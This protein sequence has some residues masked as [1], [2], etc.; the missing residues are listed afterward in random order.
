MSDNTSSCYPDRLEAFAKSTN[1]V[2]EGLASRAGKLGEA[3]DRYTARCGGPSWVDCT[4]AAQAVRIW[5]EQVRG[6]GEFAGAV[7]TAFAAADG[8]SLTHELSHLARLSTTTLDD[9]LP[10]QLASDGDDLSANSPFVPIEGLDLDH[11]LGDG[12]Q[13]GARVTTS[14]DDGSL[15]LTLVSSGYD[16]MNATEAAGSLGKFLAVGTDGAEAVAAFLGTAS[17]ALSIA[18][19]FADEWFSEPHTSTGFRTFDSAVVGGGAVG[20]AF[21]GGELS[22][23]GCSLLLGPE[24][25]P[26]CGAV[27]SGVASVVYAFGGEHLV[28]N[29]VRWFDHAVL[30][31]PIPAPNEHDVEA[32][33]DQVRQPHLDP[34]LYDSIAATAGRLA[35][36]DI[37][38]EV[39]LDQELQ[40]STIAEVRLLARGDQSEILGDTVEILNGDNP[41]TRHD[42]ELRPP[43]DIDRG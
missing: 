24:A 6:L 37:A 20:A 15:A 22:A 42:D 32:I 7:A 14:L 36:S 28:D 13:R 10:S 4:G 34:E 39:V 5:A 27:G 2:W 17:G 16:V 38:D 1:G 23:V 30:H 41:A 26:A 33:S 40:R 12:N 3:V 21:A 31:E 9:R 8:V 43:R 19:G 25:S 11:V 18:S 29:A 35:E